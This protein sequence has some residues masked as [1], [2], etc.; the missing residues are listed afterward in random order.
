[1]Q[2]YS[3][4]VPHPDHE[5]LAVHVV[6]SD[7]E[8]DQVD[9]NKALDDDA[10]RRVAEALMFTTAMH[11]LKASNQAKSAVPVLVLCLVLSY[12]ARHCAWAAFLLHVCCCCGTGVCEIAPLVS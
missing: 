8:M 12:P 2:L 4:G 11:H 5:V 6:A 9:D 7:T 10:C 1:M 3:L